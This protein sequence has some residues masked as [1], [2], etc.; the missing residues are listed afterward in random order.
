MYIICAAC[1]SIRAQ[2][3]TMGTMRHRS[4]TFGESLRLIVR[5]SGLSVSPEVAVGT[6][7]MTRLS[8]KSRHSAHIPKNLTQ[9]TQKGSGT[10]GI[11]EHKRSTDV[12]VRNGKPKLKAKKSGSQ[13]KII[14]PDSDVEILKYVPHPCAGCSMLIGSS[15]R[16]ARQTREIRPS[17]TKGTVLDSQSLRLTSWRSL[18][19]SYRRMPTC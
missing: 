4:S 9:Q 12:L 6:N 13:A 15:A 1:C 10:C 18:A 5:A 17:R 19:T 3:R 2:V 16:I 7:S 11:F 8:R 14:Q